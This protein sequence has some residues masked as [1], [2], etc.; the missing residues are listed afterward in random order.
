[1]NWKKW[2]QE[3]LQVIRKLFI[4]L[5]KAFDL[6][7]VYEFLVHIINY[8]TSMDD[9]RL[10]LEGVYNNDKCNERKDINYYEIFS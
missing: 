7:L 8:W 5:K 4:E 3:V 6:Y 10:V 2:S 9:L 1:M